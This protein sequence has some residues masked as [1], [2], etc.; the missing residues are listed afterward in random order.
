MFSSSGVFF[1]TGVDDDEDKT[2]FVVV[3]YR[4]IGS[5]IGGSVYIVHIVP[6]R[7]PYIAQN[8]VLAALLRVASVSLR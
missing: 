4:Q 3:V 6:T 1:S 8:L 2:R 5:A 7:Q